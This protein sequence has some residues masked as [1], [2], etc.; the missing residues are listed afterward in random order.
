DRKEEEVARGHAPQP[1]PHQKLLRALPAQRP[2]HVLAGPRQAFE[3]K[4]DAAGECQR[5]EEGDH[6][7]GFAFVPRLSRG[8]VTGGVTRSVTWAEKGHKMAQKA[9]GGGE[10]A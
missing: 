9:S 4:V 7:A 3:R 1:G 6:G 5:Q 2:E 8:G 10:G